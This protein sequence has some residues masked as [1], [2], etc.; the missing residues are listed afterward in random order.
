VAIGALVAVG[1]V[2]GVALFVRRSSLRRPFGATPDWEPGQGSTLGL[3]EPD[4]G[5][6]PDD[7]S[8]A[9]GPAAEGS[10]DADETGAPTGSGA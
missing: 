1:V 3:G 4:D 6:G 10:G 2:A 9:G 5:G 8:A 7:L